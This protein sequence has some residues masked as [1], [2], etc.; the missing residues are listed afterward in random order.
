MIHTTMIIPAKE[1][2]PE[3]LIFIDG[4]IST[5]KVTCVDVNFDH[6]IA[7]IMCAGGISVVHEPDEEVKVYRASFVL[8]PVIVVPRRPIAVFRQFVRDFASRPSIERFDRHARILATRRNRR[9]VVL[10]FGSE[11]AYPSDLTVVD[12]R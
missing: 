1:V 4:H 7:H 3:D 11:R 8:A 6:K 9:G 2:Q 10:E 12:R 5:S